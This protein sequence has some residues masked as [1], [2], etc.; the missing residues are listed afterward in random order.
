LE[1]HKNRILM[2]FL[3]KRMKKENTIIPNILSKISY[4]ISQVVEHKL[5]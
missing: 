5:L 4:L 2:I 1:L 3:T